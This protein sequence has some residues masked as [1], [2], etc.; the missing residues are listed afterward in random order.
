MALQPDTGKFDYSKEFSQLSSYWLDPATKTI[1][2]SDRG[3]MAGQ[4]YTAKQYKV[5]SNRPVLIWSQ[6]QDWD[7][8]KEQFHC[9]LQERLNGVMVTTR[10][11]WGDSDKPAC[12]FPLS[13]F[14]SAN[15]KKE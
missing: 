5:D 13:W 8:G 2:T 11:V 3:G 12:Q 1:R 15:E 14:Q 4:V 6:H 10:D 9:V 7:A